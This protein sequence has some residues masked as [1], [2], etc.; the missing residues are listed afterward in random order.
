MLFLNWDE[1]LAGDNAPRKRGSQSRAFLVAKLNRYSST[2]IGPLS[3][4]DFCARRNRAC[5]WLG[6]DVQQ[7]FAHLTSAGSDCVS[8]LIL[9][10]VNLALKVQWKDHRFRVHLFLS[11]AIT[12]LGSKSCLVRAVKRLVQVASF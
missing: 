9:E 11:D 7:D 2:H 4:Q 1:V 6:D 3:N 8:L 10:Q 5:E 12:K